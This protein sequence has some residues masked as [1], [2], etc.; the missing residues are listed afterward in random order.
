MVGEKRDPTKRMKRNKNNYSVLVN[1]YIALFSLEQRK[2]AYET[3]Q[4][5][6][7]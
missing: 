7:K 3:H 6:N 1:T 4:D 2:T 5:H